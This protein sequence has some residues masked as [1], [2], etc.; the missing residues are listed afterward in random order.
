MEQAPRSS[1]ALKHL[2]AKQR[3]RQIPTSTLPCPSLDVS[4]DDYASFVACLKSST[5]VLAL[6]GAGLS[7]A[8]GVPTFRGAGG[9]WREHNA[10]DLATPEAFE[11]DPSLVWQFYNHRRHNALRAKPNRAHAALGKLAGKKDFLA[12]SQNIDGKRSPKRIFEASTLN[13]KQHNRLVPTSWPL[14]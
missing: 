13:L 7:A 8:S 5:R 11:R 9:F 1:K 14:S 10:T 3:R 4:L 12:I 6:L 2:Y